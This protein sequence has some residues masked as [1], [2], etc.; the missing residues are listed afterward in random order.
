MR[1]ERKSCFSVILVSPDEAWYVSE[2]AGGTSEVI[3]QSRARAEAIGAV[4][5]ILREGAFLFWRI[6]I[7]FG[8]AWNGSPAELTERDVEISGGCASVHNAMLSP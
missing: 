6:F 1:N 7:Q 3:L 2:E 4:I 5:E 8:N